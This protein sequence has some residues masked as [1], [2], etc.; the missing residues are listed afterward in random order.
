MNDVFIDPEEVS[1]TTVKKKS[2]FLWII[3]IVFSLLGLI[4]GLFCA[5]AYSNFSPPKFRAKSVISIEPNPEF[6][7]QEGNAQ[8]NPVEHERIIASERLITACLSRHNLMNLPSFEMIPQDDIPREV[9]SNLMVDKNESLYVYDLEF[10]SINERDAPTIL[11]QIIQTYE[12][13]LERESETYQ[14]EKAS[15][16]RGEIERFEAVVT[17]LNLEREQLLLG[18]S[19]KKV[20]ETGLE[21]I[22]SSVRQA[23][24]RILVRTE[25]SDKVQRAITEGSAEERKELVWMLFQQKELVGE[26][27]EESDDV[28][29]LER[30]KKLIS[31]ET[32]TLKKQI[33]RDN[34][35]VLMHEEQLKNIASIEQKVS[36]LDKR[37]SRIDN[38]LIEN[39]AK[40]R[41]LE[42]SPNAYRFR[43]LQIAKN[44][45]AIRPPVGFLLPTFG[46]GGT[47]LGALFGLAI[48]MLIKI[49]R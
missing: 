23:K 22:L 36:A 26:M 38:N 24:N 28:E 20:Q 27:P 16:T 7:R 43:R 13:H 32:D 31:L 9:M 18:A 35:T 33:E 1:M 44:P 46:L 30:F 40:L 5:F 4:F 10:D 19:E 45:E 14:Q 2:G 21:V 11:N 3:P 37:I 25:L 42:N 17:K 15:K 49:A 48:A 34:R 12:E 29:F 8:T 39:K 47:L 6:G 41:G